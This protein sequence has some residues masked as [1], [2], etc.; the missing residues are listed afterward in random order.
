MAADGER[1]PRNRTRDHAH[2]WIC[3]VVS[4]GLI[5]SSCSQI[6]EPAAVDEAPAS[7]HGAPQDLAAS[8]DDEA[9][10]GDGTVRTYADTP[11]L[12]AIDAAGAVAVVEA[13]PQPAANVGDPTPASGGPT[14]GYIGLLGTYSVNDVLAV[15]PLPAP[16]TLPGIAPLTG[17]PLDSNANA[18]VVKIDNSSQA[19]PQ[20]GLNAADVVIEEEVEWGIT[21]F[22]AIFHTN[23]TVV[24]PVRSGRSTDISFLSSL[25][26]PALV[27]SGANDIFDALLLNQTRVRN[28]SAA[29]N[30]GYWRE[31]GRRAPSNLFTDTNSFGATGTPPPAWFEFRAP[32]E[33]S[34]G[35]PTSTVSVTWPNTRVQ[36]QW[37]GTAWLRTQNGTPHATAEGEQ[38]SAANIVVATT[39]MVDSGLGDSAGGFVPEFVWAGSGPV[40]V[41]TDG[42]RIDGMWYRPTLG[43][44]AIL[45][46][47]AGEAI[48][49]TPG[50]TW[51]EIVTPGLLA[52]S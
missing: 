25:G 26:N 13:P 47:P 36:W 34:G 29:R 50:R 16:P 33:A 8:A 18:T 43:D 4:A 6:S 5:A 52:S 42:H 51:I 39:E 21:R 45:V 38:A 23:Q 46:G 40:T 1:V 41:F 37:D 19:R 35:T 10:S 44:P 48:Q 32:G 28:F 31:S 3:G 14:G 7:P 15:S 9:S 30:G 22:A 20:A 49:L 27:Y 11:S 17:L 2:R 24:G 12:E